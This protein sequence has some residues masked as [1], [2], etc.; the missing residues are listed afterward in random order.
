MRGKLPPLQGCTPQTSTKSYSSSCS[1]CQQLLR[2]QTTAT[3]SERLCLWFNASLI[4]TLVA[5]SWGWL[6]QTQ[7][8]KRKSPNLDDFLKAGQVQPQWPLLLWWLLKLELPPL[9]QW[10]ENSERAQF[11][12]CNSSETVN[13]WKL[14]WHLCGWAVGNFRKL[15]LLFCTLTNNLRNLQFA[16]LIDRSWDMPQ[17]WWVSG[18]LDEEFSSFSWS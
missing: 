15:K 16:C 7:S 13:S 1:D 3:Q 4:M 10:G 2:H 11:W 5:K 18:R 9:L 8:G 6:Q 12:Q 14:M 17:T